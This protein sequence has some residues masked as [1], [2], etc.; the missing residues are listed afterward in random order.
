M[1]GHINVSNIPGRVI[2]LCD[3]IATVVGLEKVKAG[4]VLY[5]LRNDVISGSVSTSNFN[6][7]LLRGL[8]LNLNED[9][10]FVIVLGNDSLIGEG[11]LVFRSKNLFNIGTSLQ[12][13]G[14]VVNA[15][16]ISKVAKKKVEE[17]ELELA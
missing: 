11:T 16:G 8:V 3:G 4:E 7:V 17:K 12:L 10:I 5:F 15:V 1:G 2:F 6:D 9:N 13:F 14:Q